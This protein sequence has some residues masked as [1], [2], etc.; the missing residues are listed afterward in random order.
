MVFVYPL[1]SDVIELAGVYFCP[2]VYNDGYQN[3]SALLS[4]KGNEGASDQVF[5]VR[6][7]GHFALITC[8]AMPLIW[9]KIGYLTGSCIKMYALDRPHP[10]ILIRDHCRIVYSIGSQTN[11]SLTVGVITSAINLL[12]VNV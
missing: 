5:M 8:H 2:D 12:T 11:E 3:V 4:K 1:F 6:S 9:T 10:C 7:F